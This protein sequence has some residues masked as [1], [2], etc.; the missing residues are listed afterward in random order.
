[1]NGFINQAIAEAMERDNA[2]AGDRA[3][4]KAEVGE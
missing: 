1:M 4:A 3:G 2:A